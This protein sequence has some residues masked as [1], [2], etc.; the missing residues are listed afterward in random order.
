MLAVASSFLVQNFPEVMLP[1]YRSH[2]FVCIFFITFVIIGLYGLLQLT[3]AV[4]FHHFQLHTKD[5]LQRALAYRARALEAAFTLVSE[6]TC[7][8]GYIKLD[9]WTKLLTHVRP[10]W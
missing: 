2:W 3:T 4:V 6:Y 1:S 9:A 7:G 10:D 5:K 8:E